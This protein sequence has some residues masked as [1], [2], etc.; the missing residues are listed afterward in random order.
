[1]DTVATL[2]NGLQRYCPAI[3]CLPTWRNQPLPYG[4][5]AGA[6]DTYFSL[7]FLSID[8]PEHFVSK[9]QVYQNWQ[10]VEDEHPMFIKYSQEWS[11][12]PYTDF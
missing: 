5:L 7:G 2:W 1:M 6:G 8:K 12:W 3:D 9:G 11:K 10:Q 4:V